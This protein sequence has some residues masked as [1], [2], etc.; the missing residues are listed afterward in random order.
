MEPGL[1]APP[2]GQDFEHIERPYGLDWA[3]AGVEEVDTGSYKDSPSLT[4]RGFCSG[5]G[6]MGVCLDW[7]SA[8]KKKNKTSLNEWEGY[9]WTGGF[10]QPE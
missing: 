10:D 6:G 1:W 2:H 7:V 4:T 9:W 8:G 5:V 3:S